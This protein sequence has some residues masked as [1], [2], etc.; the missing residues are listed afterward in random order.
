[1]SFI[2]GMRCTK[3]GKDHAY[4]FP[5]NLCPDCSSVL[6]I[7]Y[8][9]EKIKESLTLRKLRNRRPGVW[10]YTELLPNIEEKFRVSL[11]EGGTYLHKCDRLAKE[12][13]LNE[14]Y[15]KDDT[16]NPTGSFLDRG[17]TIEISASKK[18]NISS[19]HNR[20]WH[21][22]NMSASLVAYSARAGLRSK[23]FIS[24][25]G[26]IDMGKFYQILAFADEIEIVRD[27][28][29]AIAK[30]NEDSKWSHVVRCTN[31]HF[32]EGKKTTALE[33]YEQLNWTN[34]DWIIA[35]M[36]TGGHVSAIWKGIRELETMGL[37]D[38]TYPRI[39]GAQAKGCAPIV[40][41]YEQ[42]VGDVTPLECT[43]TLALPLAMLDPLC[44][45]TALEAISESRG[46]GIA[47][48]DKEILDAV[49]LLAK[50]EG[51]F[52]EPASAT[53]IAV[54]QKAIK[55]GLVR[56]DESV[57]CIITGMGLKYPDI[58]KTFVKGK[59]DLTQL[60]SKLEGRRVTTQMGRTKLQILRILSEGETYGYDIWKKLSENSGIRVKMPAI[61]QHLSDLE[62]SG[63]IVK[64]R[65]SKVLKRQRSYYGISER[66]RWTIAQLEKLG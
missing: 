61:Y 42:D 45:H 57:V 53:T 56:K 59:D 37:I 58:A 34:P 55:K 19:V 60:L 23:T 40:K 49:K 12:I 9:Y 31:P 32:L 11:G 21:A 16:T 63:L 54:L 33:V 3:C 50:L 51:V 8:D 4:T 17:M 27:S 39:I 66:G 35:P 48:T 38:G 30:S 29:Q 15:L 62:N 6:F 65:T 2:K 44:G 14:L 47:V 24:R 52:A 43:T 26:N 18:W 7:H 41:A 13:G 25:K 36:G 28:E 64:A 46:Q 10:K 22:G 1:M 5:L 20:T